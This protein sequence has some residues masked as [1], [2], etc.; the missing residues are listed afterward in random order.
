MARLHQW[1]ATAGIPQL[2]VAT[3]GPAISFYRQCGWTVTEVLDRDNGERATILT[4]KLPNVVPTT[5][6]Q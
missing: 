2:W 4:I 1:A 5:G 3:G 6:W